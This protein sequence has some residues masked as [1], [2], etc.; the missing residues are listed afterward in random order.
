MFERYT[1]KARR[2]IFFA[3]Y[4]AS[5]FGSPYIE[6]EHLLLGLL[7]ENKSLYRWLPETDPETLRK[8]VDDHATRQPPTLTSV[9]LPLSAASKRVLKYAADEA[10]ALSHKHI[11]TEHLFLGLVDEAG[12]LADKLLRKAGA[13]PETVRLQLSQPPEP[14]EQSHGGLIQG[15]LSRS[16]SIGMLEIHGVR[17]NAE[18]VREAVQRCRM[19]N[20]HWDKRPWTNLDIVVARKT[21]KVSFDLSLAAD[22]AN[23]ELVKGGWRK[24]HCFICRWELF[25]PQSDADAEHGTGYT[26]GHDWLCAEC[27]TKFWERS[28]FFSSAYSD[29]T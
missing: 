15:R 21:G 19:Y 9:D 16:A 26:N 24:D 20:W 23:F 17:R 2:V 28:D 13:D 18:R 29:I 12:C 22:S 1:E 4:E 25:E 7:R 5:Q 6:T 8:R 11:G 14:Q 3:R 27:Y 10:D